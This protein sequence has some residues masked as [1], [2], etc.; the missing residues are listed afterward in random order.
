MRNRQNATLNHIPNCNPDLTAQ[1]QQYPALAQTKASMEANK[2]NLASQATEL[3]KVVRD[4]L[5][6]IES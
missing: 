4:T 1:P 5:A 3:L 2:D 6:N